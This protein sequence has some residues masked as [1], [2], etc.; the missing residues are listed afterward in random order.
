MLFYANS[1]NDLSNQRKNDYILKTND[2]GYED[3]EGFFIYLVE[4]TELQKLME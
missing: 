3:L 1:R 4:K 2:L